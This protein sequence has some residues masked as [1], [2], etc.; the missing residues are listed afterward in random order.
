MLK[1]CGYLL[2]IITISLLLV[3]CAPV[4]APSTQTDE[5]AGAT[6]LVV[7]AAASLTNVFE[8]IGATFRTA[9]PGVE[10]VFNFAGSNQLATQ[11]AEG[12]PADLFA[13]AN[14]AQM[15]VALESGRI[16]A[17]AQRTFAHNRLVIV[18]PAD[19]PA[20]LTALDDLRQS[21]LK[22]VLAA[23]DVPVGRYALDFLDRAEADS[24]LGAGYK[25]AVLANVVSYETNVR[26]V[27][28]KVVLG[29][30]DAGIV[31]TSDAAVQSDQLQQ[32]AI[33]DALNSIAS[34]P[35]A[36]LA[37]SQQTEL[38]QQFVDFVLGPDGQ[39]VL[40]AYGFAPASGEEQ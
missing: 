39:T 3:S 40:A 14:E 20:G 37:D 18:L 8:E 34:Y 29:E 13:S 12:A 32:I 6:T 26:A 38:A 2:I 1:L 24:S 27:L 9:H 36:P 19:N 35:I 30:A 33:P 21:G 5:N 11:I 25:E 4:S 15:A 31:Y 10:I 16:H 22:I 23:A 7:F 17:D 28:S